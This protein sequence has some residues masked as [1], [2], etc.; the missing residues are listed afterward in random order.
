M[1]TLLFISLVTGNGLWFW[2][3]QSAEAIL[4]CVNQ[5]YSMQMNIERSGGKVS[6]LNIQSESQE[7]IVISQKEIITSDNEANY[8]RLANEKQ[9]ALLLTYKESEKSILLS[10]GNGA[11]ELADL[12]KNN[13]VS[14]A[15]IE[16]SDCSE[17]VK[18]DG[19]TATKDPK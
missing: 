17:T 5:K 18:G 6:S 8:I 1:L 3:T 10:H 4:T 9:S 13:S 15:Q 7:P 2:S 16:F 11:S 19:T 12:L 14:E